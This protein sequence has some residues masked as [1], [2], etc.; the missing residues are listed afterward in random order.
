M[1]EIQEAY[2]AMRRLERKIERLKAAG[3]SKPSDMSQATFAVG[4]VRAIV[5]SHGVE[6]IERN[7][8]APASLEK[9]G[10]PKAKRAVRALCGREKPA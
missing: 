2:R 7:R 5:H 3:T 9:R 4:L 1:K 10:K 6:L 8:K